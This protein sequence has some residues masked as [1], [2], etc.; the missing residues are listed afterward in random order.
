MKH[1]LLTASLCMGLLAACKKEGADS[2][3]PAATQTAVTFTVDDLVQSV[4]PLSKSGPHTVSA[5]GDTLSKYANYLS[6]VVFNAKGVMIHGAYHGPQFYGYEVYDHGGPR[7]LKSATTVPANQQPFG[8]INDKLDGGVYT[9]VFI[10]SKTPVGIGGRELR[11]SFFSNFDT[12]V[13]NDTFYKKIQVT[14]GASPLTQSV[15]L[16]R[17]VAGLEVNLKS[18]LPANAS[19]LSISLENENSRLFIPSGKKGGAANIKTRNFS[20]TAADTGTP[21]KKFMVHV[22]NTETPLFVTIRA[23]DAQN[24][25]IKEKRIPNVRFFTNQKTVL[26]GDLDGA[27]QDASFTITVNPVWDTPAETIDI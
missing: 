5:E 24:V 14:V 25:L 10:A 20:L 1:L 16:D 13:W 2:P 26:S 22:L 11:Y 23:Y 7:W 27:P 17:V 6:Y 4:S 12:E 3:A 8:V 15:R 19:R 18:G 9:V 21:N